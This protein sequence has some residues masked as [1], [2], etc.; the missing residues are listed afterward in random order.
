MDLTHPEDWCARALHHGADAATPVPADA[1][2]AAEWVRMKC[3]Y[4]CDEPGVHRTCPP[5]LPPVA[6]TQRLLTEYRRGVLLEVGPIVGA[7]HSDGESR[8]LNEAALALE[9]DLSSPATTRCG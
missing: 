2:I 4:G 3:L 1:V 9:R 8:R 7:E 5:N 6:V